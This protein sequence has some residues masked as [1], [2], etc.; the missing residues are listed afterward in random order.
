[1]RSEKVG[2]ATNYQRPDRTSAGTLPGH[3]V[4]A[5]GDGV[6]YIVE[7]TFKDNPN[8]NYIVRTKNEEGLIYVQVPPQSYESEITVKSE[9]GTTYNPLTFTS[10]NFYNNLPQSI[11]N[12]FYVEHD[13]EVEGVEILGSESPLHQ[14]PPADVKPHWET[15]YEEAEPLAESQITDVED[16]AKGI[17]E[18]IIEWIKKFVGSFKS[19]S[20]QSSD[21]RDSVV[22]NPP[23]IR[24][25]KSCCLDENNNKICDKDEH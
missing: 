2:S 4:K 7:V 5:T 14:D 8:L 19:K 18:R 12:G 23:Y 6:S 15:R 16:K 11:E 1:N 20:D 21:R 24:F 3:Y 25:E 9:N 17:L 13:F 10:N 22:C